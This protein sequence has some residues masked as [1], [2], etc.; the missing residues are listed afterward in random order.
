VKSLKYNLK[1]RTLLAH[2]FSDLLNFDQDIREAKELVLSVKRTTTQRT[3]S[4]GGGA[5]E[6]TSRERGRLPPLE[7]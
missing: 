1:V 2:T 4:R 7:H 3:T 5:R 6:T